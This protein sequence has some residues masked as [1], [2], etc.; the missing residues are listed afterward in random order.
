MTPERKAYLAKCKW[1]ERYIRDKIAQE[2]G[3]IKHNKQI[4]NSVNLK[5]AYDCFAFEIDWLY[6]EIKYRKYKLTVLRHELARL[7]GMD[8]VVVPQYKKYDSRYCCNV[9]WC[10]C[11]EF[12]K[13]INVLGVAINEYCPNC[14]RHVLWEKV[15]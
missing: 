15:K 2:K 13:Q 9:G 14:G 12:L 10:R 3:Y 11:G 4:L 7:K 6:H 5:G 8:R 1:K